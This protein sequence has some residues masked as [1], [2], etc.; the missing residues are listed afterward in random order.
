MPVFQGAIRF[1]PFFVGGNLWWNSLRK[2][3]LRP[4]PTILWSRRF[5]AK[6]FG[7][8][9]AATLKFGAVG[10]WNW[11]E[12]LAPY[13]WMFPKIV[14][15]PNH[16]FL[17]GISIINHPF[18]GTTIFG[19][20]YINP[21]KNSETRCYA[22]WWLDIFLFFSPRKLGKMKHFDS[23]FSDGWFNHQLAQVVQ[24]FCC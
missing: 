23:Y 9:T 13:I 24:Q 7:E 2:L 1:S 19:N 3:P 8:K 15:P 4:Y 21:E 10:I 14:V 12:I 22:R 16:P 20:T 18:W 5:R 17:I 11:M 6:W